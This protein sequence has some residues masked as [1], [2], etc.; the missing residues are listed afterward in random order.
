METYDVA[1]IGSGPGGYVAAIRASQLGMKVVCIEKSPTFGGTCL[2][3]GCIPSKALLN[4][5]E[6]YERVLKEGKTHGLLCSSLSIDFPAMMQRKSAVV[7]ANTDGV[8]FLFKKNKIHTIQG[9]AR[10]RSATEIQVGTEILSA[11]NIIL[12]TGSEPIGLPFLPFDEKR[13]ITS[14][15]ALALEKIPKKLAVIGA[16]VIGVELASVYR[17]LGSEVVVVEMLGEICSGLDETILRSFTQILQKQGLVFHLNAQVKDGA[18]NSKKISLTVAKNEEAPFT[19]EADTVLVAIGRRPFTKNLGLETIGIAVTDRGQVSVNGLFQTNIPNIYAIGDLIEGPML[20]HKASEEGVAAAEII[21]GRTPHVNYAA[22]PNIIYT[23]PEVA[24]LGFTEKEAKEAHLDIFTG[25]CPFRS[26]PRARC[27]GE[28]E[29]LV[30]VIGEKTSGQLIGMHILGPMAS[31]L[32]AEGMLAIEKKAT[33]EQL[34]NSPNGHPTLSE[35]VKEACLVA[36][37]RPINL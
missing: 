11:K 29:G 26:N 30:K 21:A 19:I 18:I 24:A 14:T 2:N 17:R 10:L 12:A 34:A 7:K 6:L 5:S 27:M 16:G 23:Y 28:L 22:I 4:D 15:G 33:V 9:E 20:A 37:G 32:I 35:A 25:T 8:A 36:L 3:I 1:V 31:E 13:I